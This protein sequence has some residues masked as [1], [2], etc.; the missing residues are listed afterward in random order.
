MARDWKVLQRL[1]AKKGRYPGNWKCAPGLENLV[2]Q[3]LSEFIE[4]PV[5]IPVVFALDIDFLN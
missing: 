5:E 4:H 3:L 2:A 1:A